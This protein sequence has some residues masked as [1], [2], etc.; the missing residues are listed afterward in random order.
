[1][2]CEEAAAAQRKKGGDGPGLDK[3]S[4]VPVFASSCVYE[5]RWVS[6]ITRVRVCV[7]TVQ[8]RGVRS[9]QQP[10]GPSS[11]QCPISVLSC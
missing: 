4:V 10:Q 8:H 3:E 11:A 1:M 9:G 6:L 5:L 2:T 7:L